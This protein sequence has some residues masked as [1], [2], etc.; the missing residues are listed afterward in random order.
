MKNDVPAEIWPKGSASWRAADLSPKWSLDRWQEEEGQERNTWNGA[1]FL[2]QI[3]QS[4]NNR[5]ET[6]TNGFCQFT[7]ICPGSDL[8]QG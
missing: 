6:P 5:R 1:G 7:H 2:K 3:G 8:V 4:P